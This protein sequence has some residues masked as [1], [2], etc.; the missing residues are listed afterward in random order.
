[1]PA[2]NADGEKLWKQKLI[3]GCAVEIAMSTATLHCPSGIPGKFSWMEFL[4]NRES[5]AKGRG[6]NP[7]G[8]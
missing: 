1:M 5:T 4:S 2:K 6:K 3:L 8:R 7:L